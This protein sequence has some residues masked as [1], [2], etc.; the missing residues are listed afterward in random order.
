MSITPGLANGISRLALAQVDRGQKSALLSGASPRYYAVPVRSR[1]S[2][3]SKY[4]KI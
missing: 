2:D 4:L 1:D 3:K